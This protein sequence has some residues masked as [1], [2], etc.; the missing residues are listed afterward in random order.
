MTTSIMVPYSLFRCGIRY[1][2]VQLG[3]YRGPIDGIF[4]GSVLRGSRNKELHFPSTGARQKWDWGS[5]AACFG[6][7]VGAHD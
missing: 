3:D 1:L 7:I 4:G 2:Y 5:P 6:M